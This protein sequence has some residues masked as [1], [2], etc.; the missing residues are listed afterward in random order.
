MGMANDCP[1][2]NCVSFVQGHG[3]RFSSEPGHGPHS[4]A[5][6]GPIKSALLP[7]DAAARA[8]AQLALQKAAALK[9][10]ALKADRISR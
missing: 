3:A 5:P 8:R 7:K 4:S 6:A 10:D 9:S 2:P 1:D